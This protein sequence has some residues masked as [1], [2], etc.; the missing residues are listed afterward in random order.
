M[1]NVIHLH[2]I[3][4]GSYR[5]SPTSGAFITSGFLTKSLAFVITVIFVELRPPVYCVVAMH[6]GALFM[7]QTNKSIHTR[8]NTHFGSLFI[9][10]A[11]VPGL[12]TAGGE[13]KRKP[14]SI[15][16]NCCSHEK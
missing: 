9:F 4:T 14:S 6:P 1:D 15:L 10:S 3:L 11:P 7:A 8:R 16:E 13:G 5:Q 12:S 2:T